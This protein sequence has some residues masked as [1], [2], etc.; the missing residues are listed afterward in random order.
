M[1]PD[2]CM[3]LIW[4]GRDVMVA[5]P[6]TGAQLFVTGPGEVRVGLRFA[7][8]FGPRVVDVPASEVTDGRIPLDAL[9][10]GGE[11]RRIT[12]TLAASVDVGETLEALVI[13][14]CAPDPT[15][16]LVE[17]VASL[18][19]RGWTSAEIAADVGLG[20][21]QLQ[22]RCARAFG[23]G[24]KTL[25]RILRLQ[26]ALAL[27]RSG[28]PFAATAS[29]AGYA[30]QAHLAREVKDLTGVTLRRLMLLPPE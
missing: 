1:L 12:D 15:S 17:R 29:E 27:A 6:D 28:M 2:G 8:G 18:A 21:R 10:P 16:A 4:N 3:D 9:W 14:R 24:A 26:R 23:Y 25:V 13:E 5:G 20:P 11:V 7:P 19:A 30:D 22:R